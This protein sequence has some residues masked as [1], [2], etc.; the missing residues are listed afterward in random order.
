[1]KIEITFDVLP[2]NFLSYDI[3][4]G[5]DVLSE[6]LAVRMSSKQLKFLKYNV[7]NVFEIDNY[8]KDLIKV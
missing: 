7:V 6:D 5:A 4:L 2:D 8:W 1:M 3:I